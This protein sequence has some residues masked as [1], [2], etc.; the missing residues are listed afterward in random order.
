MKN[1]YDVA[2]PPNPTPELDFAGGYVW[3]AHQ[4][5][6]HIWTVAEWDRARATSRY[7]LP[8][9]TCWTPL[10]NAAADFHNAMVAWEAVVLA[11]GLQHAVLTPS[12]FALDME[13]SIAQSPG[14]PIYAQNWRTAA[15]ANGYYDIVYSSVSAIGRLGQG[16]VWT[17]TQPFNLDGHIVI[18]Q[19]GQTVVNG[20]TVDT[21]VALDVVPFFDTQ[22]SV[23]PKGHA[24]FKMFQFHDA[25]T[26]A[27]RAAVW[28]TNGV[29][30]SWVSSPGYRDTLI[31]MA[32]EQGLPTGI[33]SVS[34]DQLGAMP[35][36]G[37]SPTPG[38]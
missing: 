13:I 7:L 25:P 29:T 31:L 12:A 26:P 6:A 11:L 15:R 16:P 20:T 21:D 5:A 9:A 35:I 32:T 17:F 19:T 10:G 1:G 28:A 8:I 36:V 18:A 27:E 22:S 34:V 4:E 3:Q 23:K 33:G 38:P 37:P 24:M 2:V 30:R 14:A